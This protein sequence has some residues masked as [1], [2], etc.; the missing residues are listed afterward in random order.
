[1][2]NQIKI[3]DSFIIYRSFIDAIK[4]LPDVER[5][6]IFDAISDYALDGK[7]AVL[8][9]ISYTVFT[10]I[11]PQLDANRKRFENGCK[12]KKKSKPEAKPKRT[13]SKPEANDNVND[14]P[15]PNK[16]PNK[17][18]NLNLESEFEFELFWQSYKPIH[19]GK[20]NKEK[21]K[22]L[23]LKALKTT[24]LESIIKGLNAYMNHCQ[25]KNSYTKSVEVWLKNQCWNDEYSADI[26]S[27]DSLVDNLNKIIGEKWIEK[28]HQVEDKAIISISQ[29]NW[30]KLANLEQFKRDK[31]KEEIFK[32]LGNLTI[33]QKYTN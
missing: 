23:F 33:K 5:L 25:A 1:M 27:N 14:N 30:K 24:P 22:T 2:K 29:E 19:T 31:I 21:S 32:T 11:K 6:Q 15:N 12:D 16:N 28:V 4:S 26:Q 8:S 7:E 17:N 18:P 20:G 9:G 10:L 3:K 13:R